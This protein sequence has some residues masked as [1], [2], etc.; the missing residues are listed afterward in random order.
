MYCLVLGLKG[1]S[2]LDNP[3][4]LEVSLDIMLI[5]KSTPAQASSNQLL[6]VVKPGFISPQHHHRGK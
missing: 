6:F 5:T 3:F 4:L 1:F 2:T